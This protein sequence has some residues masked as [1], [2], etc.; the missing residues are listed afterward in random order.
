[1]QT[2]GKYNSVDIEYAQCEEI[3][4]IRWE[5]RGSKPVKHVSNMHNSSDTFTVLRTNGKEE[6]IQ[7]KFPTGI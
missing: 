6:Q 5:D 2:D 4:V 7:V 1:M 3:G